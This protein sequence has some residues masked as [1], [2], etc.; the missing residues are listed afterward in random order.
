MFR[1]H[2]CRRTNGSQQ[3]IILKVILLN[4]FLLF[5]FNDVTFSSH[6]LSWCHLIFVQACFML[7]ALLKHTFKNTQCFNFKFKFMCVMKVYVLNMTPAL[8]LKVIKCI[9]DVLY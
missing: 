5:V 4:M 1:F 3:V 8:T 7:A 6:L 2:F 9:F